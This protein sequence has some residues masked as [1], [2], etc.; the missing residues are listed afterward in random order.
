MSFECEG[1]FVDGIIWA[2]KALGL[3]EVIWGLHQGGVWS[4]VIFNFLRNPNF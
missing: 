1:G 3:C 4:C 2:P